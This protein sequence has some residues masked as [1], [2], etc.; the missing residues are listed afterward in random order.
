[1]VIP[2]NLTTNKLEGN[3]ADDKTFLLY[4]YIF[5]VLTILL[6]PL[7][8]TMPVG[9]S[10][11]PFNCILAVD[12]QLEGGDTIP[13]PTLAC[14]QKWLCVELSYVTLMCSK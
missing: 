10:G 5:A 4:Q 14:S 13:K 9:I 7:I 6:R 1:M 2:R 8:G 11:V 3:C 12:S